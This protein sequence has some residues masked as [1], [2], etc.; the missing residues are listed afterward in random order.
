VISAD[1]AAKYSIWEHSATVRDL[2]ARRC[3]MQ[4]EEMTCHAQAVELLIPYLKPGDSLLDAGC[5]SGY[6][7]HSLRSRGLK[8]D[9][10]GIDS[11]PS[12]IGIGRE[13]LPAYGL[14]RERLQVMRI[15]DLDGEVDHCVCINV[16]SNIDNYHRPLERLLQVSRRSVVLRESLRGQGS[17]SYVTDRYL[18]TGVDLKVHVNTYPLAEVEAFIR[19]YGFSVDVVTDKRVGEGPELVIDHPH[20]WKFLVCTRK[21]MAHLAPE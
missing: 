2:Y 19:S 10:R 18:D 21:N 3:R 20:Y 9:Y 15:D 17:Y 7:Y 12:L 4:A 11:S 6:F 16:L 1:G 8:V 14:E 5:G 13:I